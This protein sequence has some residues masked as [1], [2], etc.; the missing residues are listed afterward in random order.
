[1]SA[2]G[3]PSSMPVPKQYMYPHTMINNCRYARLMYIHTC[4]AC[5]CTF[6]FSFSLRNEMMEKRR[7]Y[8]V[9]LYV[10]YA[11]YDQY[12]GFS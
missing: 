2:M 12:S 9:S 1:M 3:Y 4:T 6:P 5:V 8:M 11:F 7:L 10:A